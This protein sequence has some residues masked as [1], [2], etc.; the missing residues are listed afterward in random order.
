MREKTT[1][2]FDVKL[3][4]TL[5]E[6][7]NLSYRFGCQRP[8]VF[9]PG[10]YGIVGGPANDGFAGTGTNDMYSTAANWTRV[11]SSTLI[12]EVR[13]GMSYYHNVATAQGAGL[14][15]S[16]EV[17]IP[18][19]NLDDYTSGLSRIVIGA[20][21]GGYTAPVHRLLAQPAR[22]IARRGPGTSR[23]P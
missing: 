8:V 6:K 1:N 21:T 11:F 4:Y 7:N 23:R 22:G 12:M 14:N 9:D 20:T 13:G 15:T 19:A 16:T 2:G 10:P 3:N 5:S 17:G 18:G